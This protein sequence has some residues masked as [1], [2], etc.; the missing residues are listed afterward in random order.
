[1][2]TD[3]D[4]HV[5]ITPERKRF[6]LNLKEVWEYR[7]LIM[8][9]TK[10]SFTIR[11]KQTILGPMWAFL[12]P[13]V[14]GLIMAL[15]FGGV[16]GVKTDGLPHVLF[17]L[18]SNAM[19]AFFSECIRGNAGTFTSNANLFGKVYFPRLT[20][21][22]SNLF[23]YLINFAIQIVI[24]F[25]V[26][27]LY[28]AKGEVTPLFRMWLLLPVIILVIGIQ[29]VSMG[30]I[31]SSMTTKYRDLAVLVNFGVTLMMYVSPV[32]YPLSQ[33]E[34]PTLRTLIM[35]NPVTMPM[36]CFRKIMLGRGTIDPL[37]LGISLAVTVLLAVFGVALFNRVEKTF[38]DT[39]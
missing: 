3:K 7:D 11:Y 37:F 34:N 8:L 20:V 1:M 38:M 35:L 22:I 30:I 21:P 39:V 29:S 17:Y 25:A 26:L 27:M 5:R 33:V 12:Y 36:E 23:F 32:V 18:C 28:V 31:V 15:V 6:D 14:S 19:W 10:K 4:I 24:V 16:I 13:L 9:M 2:K